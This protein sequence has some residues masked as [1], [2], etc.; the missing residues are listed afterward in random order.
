MIFSIDYI[1]ENSKISRFFLASVLVMTQGCATSR[2][3]NIAVG[4]VAGSA[5]GAAVGNLY[6]HHGRYK[7]YET[8]N[9]I[10]TSIVFAMATGAILNWHYLQLQ[11]NEVEISGRYSR[12]RLCNPDELIPNLSE[13]MGGSDDLKNSSWLQPGQIGK[14]AI[15]LDD[16]T[17]WAFPVFRKRFLRPELEENSVLSTRYIWEIM[18]P[19]NFVT[20]TQDP[21]FFFEGTEEVEHEGN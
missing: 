5:V 19:G 6:V 17:K 10:I 3:G 20:R 11:K 8:R 14:L 18:K 4:M 9:T 21:Q 13:R 1:V 12:Y 15:S 7:Q 2:T 16:N